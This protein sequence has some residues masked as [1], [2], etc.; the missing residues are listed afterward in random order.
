MDGGQ[1]AVAAADINK[2]AQEANNPYAS[3]C[4]FW[5]F[6]LLCNAEKKEKL[7]WLVQ[8]RLSR[9][10]ALCLKYFWS[11]GDES[12]W[13]M[14][15]RGLSN[16]TS[17]WK[18]REIFSGRSPAYFAMTQGRVEELVVKRLGVI[19]GRE[20]SSKKEEQQHQQL[21][22]NKNKNKLTHMHKKVVCVLS[23]ATLEGLRERLGDNQVSAAAL[24]EADVNVAQQTTAEKMR[25]QSE[26]AG[27]GFIP[28]IFQRS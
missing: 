13:S 8:N 21:Q 25:K 2:Q 14:L 7:P 27:G 6:S 5:P 1:A 19:D 28:S 23:P 10:R 15:L 20:L 11:K 17:T 9:Y 24:E 3:T 26:S 16:R 18:V 4:T 12:T 22:G